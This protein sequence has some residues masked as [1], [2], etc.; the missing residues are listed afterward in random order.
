MKKNLRLDDAKGMGLEKTLQGGI[1]VLRDNGEVHVYFQ[2]DR[3]KRAL[4]YA[5]SFP[6]DVWDEQMER[7]NAFMES[8]GRELNLAFPI[9]GEV[10][11]PL[12]PG[13]KGNWR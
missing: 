3:N 2:D 10:V 8:E 9:E 13:R 12:N 11:A 5:S 4:H 1:Y 7:V 6:E